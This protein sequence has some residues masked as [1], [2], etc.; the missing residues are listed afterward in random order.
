MISRCS[1][2]IPQSAA[3]LTPPVIN[4]CTPWSPP[5]RARY[6]RY[7]THRRRRRHRELLSPNGLTSALH[8]LERRRRNRYYELLSKFAYAVKRNHTKN[9]TYL[10]PPPTAAAYL[11]RNKVVSHTSLTAAWLTYTE[12]YSSTCKLVMKQTTVKKEFVWIIWSNFARD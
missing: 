4:T 8:H 1:P 3:R 5:T 6:S 7:M 9:A 2:S 12:L 11:E 10:A